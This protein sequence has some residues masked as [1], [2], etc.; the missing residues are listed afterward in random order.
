VR[1]GATLSGALHAALIVAAIFGLPWM[2]S[3]STPPLE[4]TEVSF[5]TEAEFQAA[6]LAPT[7][8]PATPPAQPA[9]ATPTPTPVVEAPAPA[10]AEPVTEP[11]PA[12]APELA[13][14]PVAMPSAPD[15]ADADTQEP[16]RQPAALAAVAPP[17]P[18]PADRIDPTPAPP[19]PDLA[20]P[21][22]DTVPE[23]APAPLAEVFQPERPATAPEQ[24]V[25][26]VVPDPAPQVEP[27][28][29]PQPQTR[30]T[31]LPVSSRPLGRAG[32]MA[33]LAPAAAPAPAP[34]PA[35]QP[36]VTA[37]ATPQ[38]TPP[39]PTPP[40]QTQAPTPTPAPPQPAPS[41]AAAPSQASVAAGPPLTQGE[42]DGLKFAVSS[43]WNVPAG[44][45][46]AQDLE[47]V[48]GASFDA[49]GTVLPGSIRL[50]E[51]NPLPDPRFQQ[52]FEAGRRALIRCSPYSGLPREKYSHWQT[53]EFVFN[54][55]GMVSW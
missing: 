8:R 9:E 30:L 38:P 6:L 36:T 46:D 27:T 24:S 48:I 13:P 23:T 54:P 33:R 47:V 10:P 44:L 2:T 20:R 35:A 16:P 11:A 15:G 5:V 28:P 18:R 21:S 43:C 3:R 31:D 51:P 39:Q 26:A 40:A 49:D 37:A 12:P 53:V 25:A 1:I 22:E 19:P 4:V 14:P 42:K 32:N 52:A 41:Q 17:P 45:R 50:V 34:A 29:Q 55:E 7:Q